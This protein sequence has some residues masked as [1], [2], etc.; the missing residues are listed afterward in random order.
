MRSAGGASLDGG[1]LGCG[2]V[3]GAGLFADGADVCAQVADGRTETLA[4]ATETIAAAN[5]KSVVV[6]GGLTSISF[7]PISYQ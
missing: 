4:T 5:A 6:R 1:A 3:C 7:C 2:A